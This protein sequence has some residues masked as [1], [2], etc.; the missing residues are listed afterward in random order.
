MGRHSSGGQLTSSTTR[1]P[2]TGKTSRRLRPGLAPTASRR[3]GRFVTSDAILEKQVWVLGTKSKTLRG[4]GPNCSSSLH[5][6]APV[7]AWTENVRRART[8]TLTVPGDIEG[9]GHRGGRL[10]EYVR[11]ASAKLGPRHRKICGVDMCYG[12][13]DR[14]GSVT[15]YW[16]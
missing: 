16:F 1:P 13:K 2:A 14:G 4:D 3:V 11:R 6:P 9:R 7:V 12:A 8:H 5:A 10:V 15:Q